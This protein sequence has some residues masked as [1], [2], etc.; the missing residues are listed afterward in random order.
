MNY[1]KFVIASTSLVFSLLLSSPAFAVY[2]QKVVIQSADASALQGATI[3]FQTAAGESV[4]VEVVEEQDG[5]TTI[6]VQ[7][8]GERTDGLSES[9]TIRVQNGPADSSIP[10][11]GAGEGD[12][13]LV[14]LD[15][16]VA[17]SIP[18][19]GNTTPDTSSIPSGWSF[20]IGPAFSSTDVTPIGT[21]GVESVA[22]TETFINNNVD[23]VSTTGGELILS[24]T[25]SGQRRQ[26]WYGGLR[27]SS[28]D[29]GSAVQIPTATTDTALVFSDFALG[30]TGIGIVPF[31]LDSTQDVDVDITE[32]S[33]GF[34]FDLLSAPG[35]KHRI[36]PVFELLYGQRDI[37]QTSTDFLVDPLVAGA[38]PTVTRSQSIEQ[39]YLRLSTLL[40]YGYQFND[41]FSAFIQAGPVF[42]SF[43]ADMR[44]FENI[45]CSF[46]TGIEDFDIELRDSSSESGVGYAAAVGA[47]FNLSDAAA[48]EL[49]LSIVDDLDNATI[50]NPQSGDDLAILN[51][52]AFL[53]HESN[54]EVLG[55]VRVTF[56][57]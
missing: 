23:S 21:S 31:G 18:A 33:I 43:D 13:I 25:S 22:G 10:V 11:I 29:D 37:D 50:Q 24:H 56:S 7:F 19:S 16:G 26:T 12:S 47:A 38:E 36:T 2:G 45:M 9:G 46:C 3:S 4:P 28:G 39:T 54:G 48:I 51:Q 52:P 5:R 20:S 41:T 44:S 35:S 42:H 1:V 8:P 40:R 17:S 32:G 57:F 55:T 53:N 6:T 15:T 30:T 27:F 49:E 14:N 34:Q